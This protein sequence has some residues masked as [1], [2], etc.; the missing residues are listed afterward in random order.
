MSSEFSDIRMLNVDAGR[1]ERDPRDPSCYVY[2]IR[3]S[4][5]PDTDW[6]RLF[7]EFY[8]KRVNSSLKLSTQITTVWLNLM[9]ADKTSAQSQIDVIRT[10]ITDVNI[11]YRQLQSSRLSKTQHEDQQRAD[12]KE[13][14]RRRR[15]EAVYLNY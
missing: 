1:I 12:D 7:G 3:L 6:T 5:P 13:A 14:L 10:L 8:R 2:P 15:D 11:E 9:V 4:S